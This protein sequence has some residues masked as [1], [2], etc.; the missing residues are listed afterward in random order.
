[1][2]Q[3]EPHNPKPLA[4]TPGT[5]CD[6]YSAVAQAAGLDPAA[7]ERHMAAAR[8]LTGFNYRLEPHTDPRTR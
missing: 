2:I 7:P 4:P 3:T 8:L 5:L 6:L 1:L